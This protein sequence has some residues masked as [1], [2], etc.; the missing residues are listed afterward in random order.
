MCA[1]DGL[2]AQATIYA[3]ETGL[4]EPGMEVVV[5]HGC[6]EADAET[7]PMVTTKV[8]HTHTYTHIWAHAHR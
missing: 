2:S 1:W 5:V 8:C 6:L 4:C 3:C 7:M